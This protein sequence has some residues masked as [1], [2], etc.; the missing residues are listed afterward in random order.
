MG[1]IKE[2]TKMP[3][4][5]ETF[6]GA[7]RSNREFPYIRRDPDFVRTNRASAQTP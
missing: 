3:L 1:D 2:E 6:K 5:V 4:T 7:I